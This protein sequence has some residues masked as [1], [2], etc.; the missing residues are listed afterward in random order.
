MARI[1]VWKFASSAGLIIALGVVTRVRL[2]EA[3]VALAS[4][5]RSRRELQEE[6]SR[7]EVN[8]PVFTRVQSVDVSSVVYYSIAGTSFLS[9]ILVLVALNFDR[10]ERRWRKQRAI[11]P[12]ESVPCAIA[13]EYCLNEF[14][15]VAKM[16]DWKHRDRHMNSFS[17]LSACLQ[18]FPEVFARQHCL[19]SFFIRAIPTFTRLKRALVLIVHLHGCMLTAS[20]LFNV[21]EH[22][23]PRGRYE[24]LTCDLEGLVSSNCTATL[25]LSVIAACTM[26]LFMRMLVFRQLRRT[27][28]ISQGHPSKVH[29]PVHVRKFALAPRANVLESIGC[30]QNEHE[31]TVNAFLGTRTWV[32]RLVGS[33]WGTIRSSRHLRFYGAFPSWLIILFWSSFVGFTLFYSLHYTAYLA[34]E[35]VYHW[36]AWGLVMFFVGIL[37]IEPLSIFWWEVLWRTMVLTVAQY[38]NFGM[39]AIRAT[40]KWREM[41]RLVQQTLMFNARSVAAL[42]VQRWWR[43]VLDLCRALEEQ[44]QAAV[45]I[46]AIRKRMLQ[47]KKFSVERKWCMKTEVIDCCDIEIVELTDLLSPYVRLQCDVGNPTVMQTRVIQ[48]AHQQA[49]FNETF[50]VDVK[51]AKALYVSVWS[52]GLTTEEF[53]GRGYIT[54]RT[55]QM[56]KLN[57][58]NDVMVELFDMHHG[59]QTAGSSSRGYVN[60]RITFLDPLKDQCG[61]DHDLQSWMMPKHRMQ[62]ALSKVGGR[63]RV[64]KM[65]GGLQDRQPSRQVSGRS[66]GSSLLAGMVRGEI[67]HTP[68]AWEVGD[69]GVAQTDT[70]VEP[71]VRDANGANPLSLNTTSRDHAELD[72]PPGVDVMVPGAVRDS[73]RVG[74]LECD[75][76]PASGPSV[77]LAR[78]RSTS[79]V[80]W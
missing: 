50:F 73:P 65:L 12:E 34:E 32:H 51:D 78:P 18:N 55:L 60:L 48:E 11:V 35:V 27:C 39:H 4:L 10:T 2:R 17:H 26:Y 33:L 72:T 66:V 36:L 30:M 16:Q 74:P 76:R 25:P 47:Q 53:V 14:L 22:E 71:I 43:A 58:S 68:S 19:I 41:P 1:S 62:L 37:I 44:N 13:E 23:K 15:A 77:E 67:S 31:R 29:F 49:T 54:I 20:I 6:P 21:L 70:I 8:D 40:T 42:R 79:E 57:G 9:G 52:K 69:R 3:P 63:L 24:M 59:E 56:E 64:G 28:C 5:R 80:V 46:Q 61:D 38:W 75:S 7:H 45:R